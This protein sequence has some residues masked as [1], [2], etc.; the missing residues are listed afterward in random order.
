VPVLESRRAPRLLPQVGK[1]APS[2]HF[3]KKRR[4]FLQKNNKNGL[5]ESNFLPN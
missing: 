1:V 3:L 4:A 5:A 2:G